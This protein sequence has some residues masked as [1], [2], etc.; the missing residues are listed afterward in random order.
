MMVVI[1]LLAPLLEQMDLVNCKLRDG[2]GD[3]MVQTGY[4]LCN[5]WGLSVIQIYD[6]IFL[7]FCLDFSFSS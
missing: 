6:L 4:K 7:L 1:P 5:T 2:R 3:S